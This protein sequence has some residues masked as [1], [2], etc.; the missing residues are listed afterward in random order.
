MRKI[1]RS[2]AESPHKWQVMQCFA[3][4]KLSLQWRHNDHDSVS[5]HQPHDCLLNRLFRLRSK[6]TSK[7]RVTGLCVGN[8]PVTGE[9]P[10]QMASNAEMFPFD[11]VIMMHRRRSVL[12]VRHVSS[13]VS[14]SMNLAEL[15]GL[16]Y[17]GRDK[18]AVI[19][20][21]TF[22]NAFSWM[23]MLEFRLKFRRSLF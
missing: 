9:F 14:S 4:R 5:N 16:T 10:A 6:K 11:G 2:L 13:S 12:F 15:Q 3:L 23:K 19:Y 8:S 22:S 21:T 1:P 18:R 7:L 20:Q 17:W